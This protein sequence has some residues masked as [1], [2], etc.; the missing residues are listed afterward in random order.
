MKICEFTQYDLVATANPNPPGSIAIILTPME[1]AMMV[2][3]R[4]LETV[5][6][7]GLDGKE[8]T[9]IKLIQRCDV[10]KNHDDQIIEVHADVKHRLAKHENPH[11]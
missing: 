7:A 2:L 5:N 6:R 11:A 1:R 4:A 3:I 10:A 9:G 8:L